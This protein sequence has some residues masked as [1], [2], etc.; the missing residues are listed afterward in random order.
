MAAFGGELRYLIIGGAALNREVENCLKAIKF[1]YTVG[2]GMTECGPILGYED[3]EVFE[4]RSC[5]KA[6]HRVEVKINSNDQQNTVGEILV[7]GDNVMS[8]YYKNP[9]ATKNIFTEDG[10]MRTGDLGVI[11]AK[12][13]IFIRG[14]NKSMILGSSGQNIYP[15][16]VEDKLN[17]M[18][19]VIESVVVER[20]GQLVA[21]VYPD[22]DAFKS[23][24]AHKTIEE[25]MEQIGRA[26]V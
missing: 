8:G 15:E 24:S 4:K 25:Q 20:E 16:E 26:H 23:E 17:T 19:Y 3:W 22:L 10:W 14:R 18:D 21:L 5:G 11:D 6:V 12:G 13:N 1:P 7:R 9:V 2:Y